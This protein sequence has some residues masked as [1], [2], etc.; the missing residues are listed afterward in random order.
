MNKILLIIIGFLFFTVADLKAQESF[1]KFDSIQVIYGTLN[2]VQN[3]VGQYRTGIDTIDI[4]TDTNSTIKLKSLLLEVEL[5]DGQGSW[6]SNYYQAG[7]SVKLNNRSIMFRPL[8]AIS[9][10]SK[11]RLEYCNFFENSQMNLLIEGT[12]YSS[13]TYKNSFEFHYRIELHHYSFE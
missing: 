2:K 10:E 1:L 13:Y 3:T 7:Y 9:E 4:V 5:N 11:V 8:M 12:S 6:G